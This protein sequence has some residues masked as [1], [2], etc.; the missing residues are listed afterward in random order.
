MAQAL[1]AIL[2]IHYFAL[3]FCALS[4]AI[5]ENDKDPGLIFI[6]CRRKLKGCHFESD[7]CRVTAPSA[8]I[9]LE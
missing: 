2:L 3:S 1:N 4:K 6:I 5:N 8:L 9:A 7:P